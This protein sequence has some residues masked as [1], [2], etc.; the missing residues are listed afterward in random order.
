M[1]QIKVFEDNIDDIENYLTKFVNSVVEQ[2]AATDGRK[3]RD[4]MEKLKE[5]GDNLN[6]LED[7]LTN[8]YQTFNELDNCELDQENIKTIN[9]VLE[10]GN[11]CKISELISYYEKYRAVYNKKIAS[12]NAD[13]INLDDD[14][15][16]EN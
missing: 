7:E 15:L 16:E 6:L 10:F 3:L 2:D 8:L 11:S 5:Y 9:S 12:N 13:N 14:A 4:A 1:E